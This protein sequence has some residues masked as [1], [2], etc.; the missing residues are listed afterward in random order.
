MS[1]PLP[2]VHP[3]PPGLPKPI[4]PTSSP[5]WKPQ[6]QQTCRDWMRGR[7]YRTSCRYLHVRPPIALIHN[8]PPVGHTKPR[9]G[10]YSPDRP[11]IVP[12]GH[13]EQPLLTQNLQDQPSL[14]RPSLGPNISEGGSVVQLTKNPIS[15]GALISTESDVSKHP[16]GPTM[17]SSDDIVMPVQ[18]AERQDATSELSETVRSSSLSISEC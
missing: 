12:L 7:C 17:V 2:H 18:T 5:A 16:Q 3:A 13:V 1:A 10:V 14:R 11:Q 15:D 8:N 4:L 9:F 6:V